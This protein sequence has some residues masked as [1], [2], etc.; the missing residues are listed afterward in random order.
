MRGSTM[1]KDMVFSIIRHVMTILGGAAVS[2]GITDE[3]T[4]TAIVGGTIALI[5]VIWGIVDK[6]GRG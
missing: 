3:G 5:G 4:A 2:A 1:N 6:T